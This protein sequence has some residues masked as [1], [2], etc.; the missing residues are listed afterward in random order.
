MPIAFVAAN[1]VDQPSVAMSSN[2]AGSAATNRLADD[3][4]EAAGAPCVN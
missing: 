4:G 2:A 3:L 1:Q